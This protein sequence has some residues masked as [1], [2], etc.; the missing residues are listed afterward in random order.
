[1]INICLTL[2]QKYALSCLLN[3]FRWSEACRPAVLRT[4]WRHFQHC[5]APLGWH[6][7]S[8]CACGSYSRNNSTA[9]IH[10]MMPNTLILFKPR[11]K[12]HLFS[13]TICVYSKNRSE[14]WISNWEWPF[15][16]GPNSSHPILLSQN[17]ILF[18]FDVHVLQILFHLNVLVCLSLCVWL[19]YSFTYEKSF[20]VCSD[21]WPLIVVT[22]P[23]RLTGRNN[24][25]TD[26]TP[27]LLCVHVRCMRGN[28][29]QKLKSCSFFLTSMLTFF[30]FLHQNA[31]F[32]K[33]VY[34]WPWKM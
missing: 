32:W 13:K 7:T 12:P 6:H 9:I 26:L 33:Q 1:M 17:V 15:V 21:F 14:W 24:P 19:A 8:L 4:S 28:K 27:S 22:W 29:M 18:R 31:H 5:R 23:V 34:L 11:R 16:I 2:V 25:M 20:K 3:V 10:A 30:F